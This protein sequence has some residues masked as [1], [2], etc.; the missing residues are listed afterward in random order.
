MRLRNFAIM[1]VVLEGGVVN[2]ASIR[3]A[4]LE[5]FYE[6]GN[7]RDHYRAFISLL[8]NAASWEAATEAYENIS[9]PAY[10][11]WGGEDWATSSERDHDR[12]LLPSAQTATVENGGHFLPLDRPKEVFELIARFAGGVGGDGLELASSNANARS[13]LALCDIR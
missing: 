10:L 1:K 4:L 9:V 7:R 2:P 5:E 8:R 12:S 6:V 13:G 11:I 3:P